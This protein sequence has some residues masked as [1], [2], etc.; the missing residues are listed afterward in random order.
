MS[1]Q[2][3]K[4]SDGNLITKPV[5]GWTLK[6]VADIVLLLTIQYVETPEE[7]E[8]SDTHH[9]IQFVLK[10]EAALEL[11]EILTSTGKRLLESRSPTDKPLN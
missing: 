1:I 6:A 11:A 8:T 4:D 2:L 9:Q 5:T 7:L 10:P 3:E